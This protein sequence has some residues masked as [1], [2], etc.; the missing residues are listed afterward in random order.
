M[1]TRQDNFSAEL[2]ASTRELNQRFLDLAVAHGSGHLRLPQEPAAHLA[3]LSAA[4][5]AA[6]A[7]CPY[8][9]FD[10]RFSDHTHWRSRLGAVDAWCIADEPQVDQ[11]IAGFVGVALFYAWHVASMPRLGAQLWLGM[12]EPTAAA[13]RGVSLHGLSTLVASEA[14]HL[15]A[16]WCTSGFYWSALACA[17]AHGDSRRL[18]K[19]QLFGLQLGAACLLP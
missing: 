14:A 7:D 6:A 2:R 8:A 4:Q 12:A 10:L 9:L 5:R 18:R 13:F 15:S 16:R 17:A 19:V 1:W 11:D 3:G